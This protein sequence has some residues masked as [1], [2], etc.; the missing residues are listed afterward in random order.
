MCNRRA[1]EPRLDLEQLVFLSHSVEGG[2]TYS[3][4][5]RGVVY[6]AIALPQRL[7][8]GNAVELAAIENRERRVL[9]W[10]LAGR[11]RIVT[12]LVEPLPHRG[13]NPRGKMFASNRCSSR[14]H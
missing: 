4:D 10:E 5:A 1:S 11:Y 3:K 6:A 8:H 14:S 7:D 13:E 12:R 9:R 2:P